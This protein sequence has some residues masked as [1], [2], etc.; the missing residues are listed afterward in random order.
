M[1]GMGTGVTLSVRSPKIHEILDN[2]ILMGKP[3]AQTCNDFHKCDY[4]QASRP[5]STGKLK[6]LPTLHIP[7]INVVVFH[8]SLGDYSREI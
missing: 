3:S 8:G 2:S 6:L 7:P 1:F 4:D 5:I